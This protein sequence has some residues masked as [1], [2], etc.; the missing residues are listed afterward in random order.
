MFSVCRQAGYVIIKNNK[1]R[2]MKK[3]LIISSFLLLFSSITFA[4]WDS[5]YDYFSV[6]FGATNTIF[7][8]QPDTLINKMLVA[9]NGFDH[10]QLFPDTGFNF[11]YAPGYYGSFI[12]NHDL[13]NNNVGVSLGIDYRMYGIVSNFYTNSIPEYTYREVYKISQVSVP[14]FIRYGKKFYETQKYIYGGFSF[15]Y[16][17]LISETEQ[18]GYSETAKTVEINKESLKKSNVSA[19]AGF[20][21]MFF[22][23]ELNY[24][25]GNF[26]SKDYTLEMNDGS[27]IKPYEGQPNHAFFIKTGITLPINSWTPRKVYAIEMWF[28]RLLK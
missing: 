8:A 13:K 24:V 19:L 3:L 12:Y 15:N 21:Y 5:E 7:S 27:V 23:V 20:N 17:L 25:F 9:K 14:V 28:R 6:K 1:K 22:N 18:A 11:N 2:H 16:N 4:Q 10:Y 26:L